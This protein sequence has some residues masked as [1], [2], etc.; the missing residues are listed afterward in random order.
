M[1]VLA[2]QAWEGLQRLELIGL[3]RYDDAVKNV[4]PLAHLQPRIR[5]E[6]Q[7]GRVVRFNYNATPKDISPPSGL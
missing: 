7:Q 1:L 5:V 6:Y 2:E 3:D 4:D